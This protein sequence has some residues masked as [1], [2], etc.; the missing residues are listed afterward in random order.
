[1]KL[2]DHFKSEE[3]ACKC[4]CG[5]DTPSDTLISGLEELRAILGKPIVINSGCRCASHN[6]AVGGSPSSQHINGT[7]ADIKVSGYTPDQLKAA[8]EKVA[9]F[10]NGGIGL[11]SWG[12]HVDVRGTKSRWDYR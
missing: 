8:A 5:Y 1:M 12:I 10:A 4:G 7:A 2:S 11:Y 9:C 3:F 6:K